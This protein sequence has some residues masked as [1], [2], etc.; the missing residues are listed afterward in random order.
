M[1]TVAVALTGA[2]GADVEGTRID[3]IDG[4]LATDR[5]GA[6]RRPAVVTLATTSVLVYDV[7]PDRGADAVT[8]VVTPGSDWTVTAV[9]GAGGPN[10]PRP[11]STELAER[12]ARRG[13]ESQTA[14]L[15]V[16]QGPG[17]TVTWQSADP[18]RSDPP[19]RSAAKKTP[20]QGRAGQEST[21]QEDTGQ[22]KVPA[23]T[24]VAKKAP[25]KKTASKKTVAKKTVAKKRAAPAR[26]SSGRRTT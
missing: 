19:P 22:E 17:C 11:T 6:A 18:P 1:R 2:V 10:E 16:M 9:L 15:T 4:R 12:L 25:A 3:I 8:V 23:R 20:A 13:V 7:V 26:R 24:T 5:D 21:G 14:Q